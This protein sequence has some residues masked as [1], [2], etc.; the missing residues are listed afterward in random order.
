[1]QPAYHAH[2]ECWLLSHRIHVLA[3]QSGVYGNAFMLSIPDSF[4]TLCG[5]RLA[6]DSRF[7][8]LIHGVST[9]T[10]ILVQLV[11][12]VD[13]RRYNFLP[14]SWLSQL[15]LKFCQQVCQ[16]LGLQPVCAPVVCYMQRSLSV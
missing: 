1:M 4:V 12:T 5:L 6:C 10:G 9:D 3:K 14:P 16:L 15:Q 2:V 11:R 13:C 8:R 7:D